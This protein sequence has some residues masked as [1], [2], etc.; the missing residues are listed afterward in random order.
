[1]LQFYFYVPDSHLETVKEA[2]FCAGAGKIGEY[3]ACAW[4]VRGIGQFRPGAGAN[5]FIGTPGK[6]EA[7]EEWRVEMVLEPA[8]KDTVLQAFR[9]AHPYEEPAYGFIRIEV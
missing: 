8:L 4:Q 5:P 6:A 2:V 1:M 9:Q 7:I 3:E